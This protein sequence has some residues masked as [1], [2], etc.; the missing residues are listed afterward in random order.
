MLAYSLLANLLVD[1]TFSWVRMFIALFFSILISLGVGIY[2]ALNRKAERVII[3]VLDIFQT[4]PILAFFPFVIYVFVALLPGFIGINVAVIFL[5]ITSMVWNIAFGVYESIK[6]LPKEFMELAMLYHMG[7][8]E[9]L[10]KIFIPAAMPR[11]IEQSVL[12]W[13]IGLFYL[14]TSEIFSTGRATYAV[15]YGIGVAITNLALSGNFVGYAI[16]LGVFIAFVIL[17]RFL[18]FA[19]LERKVNVYVKGGF[20]KTKEQ[21][22]L[23]EHHRRFFIMNVP[24][25]HISSRIRLFRRRA[26]MAKARE[27]AEA[28]SLQK[29]RPKYVVA[30]A[31][32]VLTIIALLVYIF[33][34]KIFSYESEVL[35]ALAASIARVWLSFAIILLIGVPLSI[36]IAFLSK[37]PGSYLLGMQI[38]ASIP[39]TV[40]LPPVAILLSRQPL[41]GELVAFFVFVLSGIWY[42]IF[43]IIASTRTMPQSIMEVKEVFQVKGKNAFR[44]IYLKAIMPGLI[45]GAVTG[46]AAEWNASIVAEY[47]TSTAIGNGAVISSV[48]VGIG[49]LLDLSLD[50]GNMLLMLI[51][52][53]NLTIMILLVN[54]FIWRRLYNNVAKVY[55]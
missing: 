50:S 55:G 13:S 23:R 53:A 14:V 17:T 37:H 5:I 33:G 47:F 6:T 52:L 27:Y 7:V 29:S 43:S 25:I 28:S 2:A 8:I 20:A 10:R 41:H 3:P 51:A 12:S 24:R 11:V 38:L 42:V 40:L 49:K 16:A 35:L 15:K 48:S 46:I 26:H 9:K 39:A 44:N 22:R 36:Y 34:A 21:Y 45:T 18:F 32:A 4:L 31:A 30:A 54:K 1:T 19:P